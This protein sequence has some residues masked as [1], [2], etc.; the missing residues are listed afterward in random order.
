[1]TASVAELELRVQNLEQVQDSVHGELLAIAGESKQASIE[2]RQASLAAKNAAER[3]ANE[4]VAVKQAIRE[5]RLTMTTR[6]EARHTELNERLRDMRS[7]TVDDDFDIKTDVMDRDQLVQSRH[8]LKQQITNTRAELEDLKGQL[9]LLCEAEEQRKRAEHDAEVARQAVQTAEAER[10]KAQQ[11]ALEQSEANDA[12]ERELKRER[13]K[14]IVSIT[15]TC[16]T[17]GGGIVVAII[18][19]F[20]R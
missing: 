2:S 9:A 19:T 16:L 5:M 15:I 13:I 12:K 20:S 18:H 17:V 3:A 10:D 14:A 4:L 6:C 7:T 8:F 1:M 11:V